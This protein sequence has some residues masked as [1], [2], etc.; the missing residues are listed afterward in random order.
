[1]NGFR[2]YTATALAA[3]LVAAVLGA[4]GGDDE[5]DTVQ[6]IPVT[7]TTGA[8]SQAGSDEQGQNGG[9]DAGDDDSGGSAPDSAGDRNPDA[10]DNSVSDRPGG[11]DQDNTGQGGGDQ[12]GGGSGGVSPPQPSPSR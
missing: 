1:M 3:I 10:P 12:G 4:C 5:G 2:K 7:G 9:A 8:T 11:P 6:G